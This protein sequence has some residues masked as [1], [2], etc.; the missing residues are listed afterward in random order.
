[1]DETK[2]AQCIDFLDIA[3]EQMEAGDYETAKGFVEDVYSMLEEEY[4][5]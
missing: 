5:G 1:M 4:D 2:L 3:V